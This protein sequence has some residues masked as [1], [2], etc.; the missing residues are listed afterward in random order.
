MRGQLQA[1]G[2][3]DAAAFTAALESALAALGY[4]SPDKK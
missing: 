4:V 1:S 3:M 2:L